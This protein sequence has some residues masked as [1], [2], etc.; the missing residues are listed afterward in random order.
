MPLCFKLFR[1]LP[2]ITNWRVW[3]P[4]IACAVFFLHY[5][6]PMLRIPLKYEPMIT[7]G[8]SSLYASVCLVFF[9]HDA[10]IM[11]KDTDIYIYL[12]EVYGILVHVWKQSVLSSFVFHSHPHHP[13]GPASDFH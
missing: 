9:F 5:A 1:L 6:L 10:L 7:T 8:G 12:I 11:L 2:F 13:R 4:T 3:I